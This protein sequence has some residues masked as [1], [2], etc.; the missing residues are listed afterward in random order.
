MTFR[1]QQSSRRITTTANRMKERMI[2]QIFMLVISSQ[3]LETEDRRERF[4]RAS[5]KYLTAAARPVVLRQSFA[6]TW[7]SHQ[8]RA[9]FH[10]GQQPCTSTVGEGEAVHTYMWFSYQ[11]L[12]ITQGTRNS[13]GI[14]GKK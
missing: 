8:R 14:P 6:L 7:V 11:Y 9:P 4:V 3:H 12:A 5:Q 10:T 1:E 13:S 2:H